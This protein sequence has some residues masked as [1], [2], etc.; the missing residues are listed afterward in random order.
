MNT[1]NIREHMEVFG[2]CGNRLGTV[3]RVEGNNIKLTKNSAPDGQ[4]HVIPVTW[5][6]NVDD[7]VHLNKT[8]GEA[9]RLWQT[10]TSNA[11]V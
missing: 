7:V 11:P 4:H 9:K 6:A 3:D 5:V 2:T 10:E 8:C 1:Q